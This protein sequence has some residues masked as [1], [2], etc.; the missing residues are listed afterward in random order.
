VADNLET[1][2]AG[3]LTGYISDLESA[4]FTV[5]ASIYPV[6]ATVEGLKDYLVDKHGEGLTGAVL[7]GELPFAWYQIDDD[8][9]NRGLFLPP[10]DYYEEFPCDLFLCDLD[11]TWVDDSAHTGDRYTSMTAGSDGIYDSHTGNREAEI[12]VSRIDASHSTGIDIIELY[13]DYFDRA[14]AYRTGQLTFPSKAILFADDPWAEE[15]LDNGLNLICDTVIQIRD[16]EA[17][18]AEDY[19]QWLETDGL[20]LTNLVHSFH[21]AHCY[22]A[23]D[24]PYNVYDTFFNTDL[25]AL[26]P[27]YGFY[28]MW[29]C[30]T[31]RYIEEDCLGALYLLLGK[32]LA[33]VGSTKEG[34]MLDFS[35]LN[36]P[37]G[38]GD[39]WG[40][41]FKNQ[42]N[43]W[44][45]SFA[46]EGGDQQ[47]RSWHMGLTI[48]GDGT[49]NLAD[50]IPV[51]VTDSGSQASVN[52]NLRQISSNMISVQFTLPQSGTVE[53]LLFD[54]A[55]RR[56]AD[57]HQGYWDAGYHSINY[58]TSHLVPGIYFVSLRTAENCT[59]RKVIVIR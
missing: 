56:V 5:E 52:V 16:P 33:T 49:L 1:E 15:F 6:S 51:S 39:C 38:E 53:L 58:D 45:T 41:A 50:Q 42:T 11:G 13:H 3:D 28:H 35:V 57:L 55:G 25:R 23:P 18:G 10:Y 34:S 24:L 4:G 31:H 47:G 17:T 30:L 44:I 20:Y 12:W 43:Y 7:I 48:F 21:Y 26:D 8:F 2:L 54:S 40:E 29:G 9:T 14:H 32:G 22:T 27:G 37:L 19:A 59:N 36:T 46:E